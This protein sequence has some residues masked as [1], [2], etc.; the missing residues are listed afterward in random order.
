VNDPSSP[1]NCAG[2]VSWLQQ[3]VD[4]WPDENALEHVRAGLLTWIRSASKARRDSEGVR[5]RARPLSLARCLGL[6]ENP[7]QARRALRDAYLRRAAA[8]LGREESASGWQRSKLL[9][10][11]VGRFTRRQW[12]CWFASDHPPP[13]AGELDRLLFLAMKSG[14][15]ALPQTA[16]GLHKVLLGCK[17]DR[18]N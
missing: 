11:E 16:R 8:L 10:Q 13:N 3:F 18:A 7:M 12:P 17:A 1:S 14:G 6:H 9:A 4:G 15:G 2:G 5:R